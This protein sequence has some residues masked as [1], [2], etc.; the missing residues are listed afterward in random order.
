[1]KDMEMGKKKRTKTEELK[2]Y[3]DQR[4]DRIEELL[5]LCMVNQLTNELA[6]TLNAI[7]EKSVTADKD[8]RSVRAD[9][10][11]K[12]ELRATPVVLAAKMEKRAVEVRAPEWIPPETRLW[13]KKE[14][15][16]S[17]I[18]KDTL[19]GG[20]VCGN[21]KSTIALKAPIDGRLE[22]LPKKERAMGF[23][24]NF[25]SVSPGEI[26]AKIYP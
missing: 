14:Y 1:M 7:E 9:A 5:K 6:E 12:K 25:A 3:F 21:S 17:R 8:A 20:L 26:I 19:I 24:L 15:D 2:D 4:L 11:E 16:G 10:T 22:F 13:L 18:Q 23:L